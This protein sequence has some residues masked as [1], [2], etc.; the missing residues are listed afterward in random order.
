MSKSKKDERTRNWVFVVYPESAPDNWRD[1]IDEHHI[2]WIESPL[3]DKDIN[4]DGTP[5]KPHWH[6]LL[7]FDGVKSFDQV[8]EVTKPTNGTIPIKC[9]SAEGSVRYW[10][11]LDNPEKA[12]YDKNL[13]IGHGGIDV[14]KYLAPRS[15]QR[16]QMIREMQ[17]YIRE[18]NVTEYSDFLDYTAENHFDDWYPLICDNCSYVIRSYLNS[19][20]FKKFQASAAVKQYIDPETGEVVNIRVH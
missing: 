3:H 12:Q 20:R 5:K 7:L 11:H 16:Y 10:A 9:L 1:L 2:Q 8:L 17:A 14:A 13:I 4:G 15:S 18:H 19:R 6:V